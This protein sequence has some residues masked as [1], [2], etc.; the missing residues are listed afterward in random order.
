MISFDLSLYHL[1]YIDTAALKSRAPP[2]DR[3]YP[4]SIVDRPYMKWNRLN[5]IYSLFSD[6]ISLDQGFPLADH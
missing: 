2:Q 5:I 4:W 6:I 3:A 1:R